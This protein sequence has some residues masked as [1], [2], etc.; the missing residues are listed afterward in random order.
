MARFHWA[1]KK[2]NRNAEI[3]NLAPPDMCGSLGRLTPHNS[4]I[5]P[6]CGFCTQPQARL[7]CN[8]RS[9]RAD[10]PPTKTR[11]HTNDVFLFSCC[12]LLLRCFLSLSIYIY[13]YIHTYIHTY[14]CVHI[15]IYIYC[16]C[17]NISLSCSCSSCCSSSI[18]HNL[19]F[20]SVSYSSSVA[21]HQ[22][23]GH[24]FPL[25]FM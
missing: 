22:D 4:S 25:I 5:R 15:Y 10:K 18:H 2:Q 3:R 12:Y 14:I 16:F 6:E 13:I 19:F 24:I 11:T 20:S 23:I 7:T 21:N 1:R 17:F 8:L 9:W